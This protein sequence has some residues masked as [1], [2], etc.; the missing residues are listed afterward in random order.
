[1]SGN[2]ITSL[3]KLKKCITM[4]LLVFTTIGG[5]ESL[6]LSGVRPGLRGQSSAVCCVQESLSPG[7]LSQV[8]ANTLRLNGAMC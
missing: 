1:M 8:R 2:G 6:A 3:F 4:A 5:A 7:R